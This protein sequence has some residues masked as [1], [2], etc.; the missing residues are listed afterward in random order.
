MAELERDSGCVMMHEEEV[1]HVEAGENELAA[2]RGRV[3]EEEVFSGVSAACRAAGV[4]FTS[5]GVGGA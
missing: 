3:L 1:E 5:S 4:G 2:A